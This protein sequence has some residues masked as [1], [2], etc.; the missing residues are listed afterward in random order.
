MLNVILEFSSE[1]KREEAIQEIAPSSYW[2]REMYDRYLLDFSCPGSDSVKIALWA[3]ISKK[4]SFVEA[5]RYS[6]SDK[7]TKEDLFGAFSVLDY[8]EEQLKKMFRQYFPQ[9]KRDI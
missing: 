4:D 1:E 7:E 5:V 9:T 3:K 8:S 6:T 2:K